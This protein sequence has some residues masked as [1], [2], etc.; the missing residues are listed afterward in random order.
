[1]YFHIRNLSV[2]N[3]LFNCSWFMDSFKK[4]RLFMLSV[5]FYDKNKRKHAK[6]FFQNPY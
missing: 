3:K 5:I 4:E 6:N 2:K 1:M